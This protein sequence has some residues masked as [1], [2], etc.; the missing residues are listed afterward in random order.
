MSRPQILAIERSRWR[1][2]SVVGRI[3]YHGVGIGHSTRAVPPLGKPGLLYIRF[4][5]SDDF[6]DSFEPR[7]DRVG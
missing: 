6:E 7:D 3:L 1:T 4:E 2:S 5:R